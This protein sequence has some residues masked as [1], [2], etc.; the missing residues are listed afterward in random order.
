MFHVHN[1]PI[2]W[3]KRLKVELSKQVRKVMA[4]NEPTGSPNRAF[5]VPYGQG[6]FATLIIR[7]RTSACS[8]NACDSLRQTKDTGHANVMHRSCLSFRS[9]DLYMAVRL[10]K[11]STKT[12]STEACRGYRRIRP[13]QTSP[14]T[15]LFLPPPPSPPP[16]VEAVC[17]DAAPFHA[18]FAQQIKSAFRKQLRSVCGRI[19]AVGPCRPVCV[20]VWSQ[21]DTIIIQGCGWLTSPPEK[22]GATGRRTRCFYVSTRRSACC[23]DLANTCGCHICFCPKAEQSTTTLFCFFL[24]ARKGTLPFALRLFF[25]VVI[26]SRYVVDR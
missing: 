3:T 26:L 5:H 1:L 10:N 21:G 18:E 16:R 22:R 17:A 24:C 15:S 11:S 14:A 23:F 8:G 12:H 4:W 2:V 19:T 9:F 6:L 20:C 7:H 25:D 13:R